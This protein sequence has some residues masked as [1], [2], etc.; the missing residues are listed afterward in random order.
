MKFRIC[1]AAVVIACCGVGSAAS[2]EVTTSAQV[3]DGHSTRIVELLPLRSAQYLDSRLESLPE[4]NA[5]VVK[6]MLEYPRD[7]QHRYWWPRSSREGSY[8]GAT[9]DVVVAGEVVMRGEPKSR[10]FCCG[11][12]LELFYKT[13]GS[14]QEL[15]DLWTSSTGSAFKELWF[16]TALNAPGPEDAMT[17]YTI[18]ER[19][20]RREDVLPGDFVQIWRNSGS[21]HSVIFVDWARDKQGK[22][23]GLHYWSTQ[24]GTNGIAFTAELFGAGGGMVDPLR[25]SYTRLKPRRDWDIT[26]IRTAAGIP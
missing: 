26:S 19:I 22:V 3:F 13:L 2:D 21:G 12:T 15:E 11:L 18:G 4:M 7:G 25:T 9:T 16:C 24:P 20:E 10:S 17:S 5:R 8:D 6:T 14:R 1:A 23:V